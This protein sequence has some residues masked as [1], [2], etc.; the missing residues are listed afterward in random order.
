VPALQFRAFL[1]G[2][3]HRQHDE[4]VVPTVQG[5]GRSRSRHFSHGGQF[6][7]DSVS[8]AAEKAQGRT[9]TPRESF[10]TRPNACGLQSS[11]DQPLLPVCPACE[12]AVGV[13]E[14]R[15]RAGGGFAA[16]VLRFARSDCSAREVRPQLASDNLPHP[17]IRQ[18]RQWNQSL[19]AMRCTRT[20]PARRD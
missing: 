5:P 14:V 17:T 7:P 6:T 15:A 3:R 10:R 12:P 18:P 4:A 13:P 2:R 1:L 9:L 16:W 11:G 19:C 20:H 8:E